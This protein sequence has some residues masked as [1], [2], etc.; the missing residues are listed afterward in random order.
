VE[1]DPVT[2]ELRIVKGVPNTALVYL[3]K[4]Q[5][6]SLGSLVDEPVAVDEDMAGGTP[7]VRKGGA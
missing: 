7:A 1:N 2:H 3:T 4:E 6:A 5:V